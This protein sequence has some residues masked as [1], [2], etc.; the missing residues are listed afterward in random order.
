MHMY[1]AY[2]VTQGVYGEILPRSSM[3]K[4]ADDCSWLHADKATDELG[5][6]RAEKDHRLWIELEA[7]SATYPIASCADI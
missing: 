5:W 1:S 3:S 7:M 2:D 6:I 4:P